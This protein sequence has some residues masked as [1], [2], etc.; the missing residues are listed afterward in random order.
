MKTLIL[1]AALCAAAVPALAQT[2]V[3]VSIGDA[4]FYGRI[5]IGDF[6]RPQVIFVEPVIIERRHVG[7]QPIYLRVPP[8]HEKKWSKHCSKYNA[9]GQPVYFVRDEWYSNTYAPR[10][11]EQHGHARDDDHEHGHDKGHDEGHG[12]GHGK[13]HGNGH[14]KH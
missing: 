10:A 4:G 11:R 2:N 12:K 5:D 8:G 7:A 13:G 6:A 1:A 3:R 9:C 14:G